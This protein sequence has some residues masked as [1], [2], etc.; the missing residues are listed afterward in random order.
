VWAPANVAPVIEAPERYDLPCLWYEPVPVDRRLALGESFRWHEYEVRVHELPGHTLYAAAFEVEVDGKRILVCGDQQSNDDGRALLNYQ[1]RNRFRS[2]DYVRSAELYRALRPDVL[3]SGHWPPLEVS[4]ELL[5]RLLE[6]GRTVERLHREL[7]PEDALGVE[8]FAARI[9]PYR[10]RGPLVRL[11][12]EVANPFDRPETATVRLVVPDG[13]TAPPAQDVELAAH[14]AGSV[15][16]ALDAPAS[17]RVAAD[18][19]V[20][21]RK[22]GQQAEAHVEVE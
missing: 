4:D 12:V 8:G 6:D 18:V 11:T 20:G 5:D 17:G 21:D 13:W 9:V 22:L 7:L 16:F 19:T 15:E 3:A 10:A 1:Y 2:G 14:G